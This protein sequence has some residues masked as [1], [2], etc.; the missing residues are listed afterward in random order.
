[1]FDRTLRRALPLVALAALTLVGV[2]CDDTESSTDTLLADGDVDT[3]ADGATGDVPPGD[4]TSTATAPGDA[5][6]DGMTT[7]P[8]DATATDDASADV[9]V[10]MGP[11]CV[12][13]TITYRTNAYDCAWDIPPEYTGSVA[14]VYI[15][16]A[17]GARRALCKST[18]AA[19]NVSWFESGDR[20]ILCDLACDAAY[21]AANTGGGVVVEYGC[22][23]E[24]CGGGCIPGGS[25]CSNETCCPG[26]HCSAS[27]CRACGDGGASCT[28]DSQC[29]AYN[30]VGGTCV[31]PIGWT[32]ASDAGCAG[33]S[34]C[35]DGDC[36][37]T[38]GTTK[39]GDRCIDLGADDPMHCGGCNTVCRDDQTCTAGA[40]VCDG[41]NGASTECDGACVDTQTDT[42]NCGACG[43]T[44]LAD[45]SCTA[46]AC[47]CPAGEVPCGAACVDLTS[48]TGNCGA[49]GTTCTSVEVCAAGTCTCAPGLSACRGTCLDLQTDRAN[50]GVCENVCNGQKICVGGACVNP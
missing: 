9:G 25:P 30:C 41:S 29:C 24:R 1:M 7:A 38:D 45:Q 23:T 47:Q 14:N 4:I 18:R 39:C 6:I 8:S 16:S 27:Q 31:S 13:D 46:G 11:D 44:C 32:C 33:G 48:D 49:C 12:T 17:S 50:C 22:E 21:D 36:T 20:V 2:A 3:A 40:C 35:V 10:D 34:R 42:A 28:V 15:E 19:C 26:Y 5:Q 37:C 43:T